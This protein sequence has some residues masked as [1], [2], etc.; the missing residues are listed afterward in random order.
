MRVYKVKSPI[1]N[2]ILYEMYDPDMMEIRRLYERAKSS[3][4]IIRNL[5]IDER[6]RECRKI[7]N[8]VAENREW[9]IDRIVIENGKS[10]FDCL[11]NEIFVVL[12]A[13]EYYKKNAARILADKNVS[14]PLTLRGK[15]SKIIY[16][17]I[18]VV[19]VLSP[20][21]YPLY[22]S[23]VP[24][25]S[26]FIAGN[27]VIYKPS[28]ITPLHG[29]IEEIIIK[30][31]FM[32]EAIQVV[33]GGP[34]TGEK[35][36]EAKP[37][38]I[39]FIG[40]VKTGKK[41]MALAARQLI[42]VVLELGGKDSMIVFDDADLEKTAIG[43]LW[44]ALTN[45]GQACISVERIYA[46]ENIY[47]HFVKTLAE[48]IVLLKQAHDKDNNIEMEY[49]DIG[50]MTA[51][52]QVDIVDQHVKDA[53]N[54]GARVLIG[55]KK[56]SHPFHYPATLIAD[57]NH[58]MKVMTEETF[59]PVLAVMKFATE[60]E[61]VRLAN[62]SPYGLGASVW[63]KDKMRADRV[64]RKIAAG[65]VCINNVML[66][67]ANPAL[68]FGGVKYSGFGRYKG[69]YGLYAFTN[70]KSI[71]IDKMNSKIEGHWFPYTPNKYKAF[72][73]LI[74]ALY[75]KSKSFLKFIWAG[76]KLES[77]AK[78]ERLK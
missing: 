28:E 29:M 52:R 45:A 66:T 70:V 58:T 60:E 33:Y 17:P 46:Q 50:S 65:N 62:D 5:S 63:S 8:Y 43:A 47:D 71:V 12:D 44:G 20:W 18:G 78:K 16:E 21:N 75:S 38:K 49:I 6:L 31:G 64:A 32:E 42:P 11:S 72:S 9:I 48:K 59:G 25:L 76:L 51:E 61:A 14:T 57:V 15:K 53:I 10:R 34:D 4:E 55:G 2:N 67:V 1:D 13:I 24:I 73:D 26:A 41:I 35:L 30:S 56:G 37:E 54:K 40:G 3:F 39:F 19:L 22:Q 27:S 68:P 7:Q 74:D 77:I 36:I 23:I 69:E